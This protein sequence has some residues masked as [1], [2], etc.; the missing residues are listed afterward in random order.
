MPQISG[1][2]LIQMIREKDHNYII[3]I[4]LISATIKDT[5]ITNYSDKL[6]DLKIDKFLEKP[7]SLNKLK[8][9]IKMLIE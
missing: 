8:D 6:S 4:I 5:F 3:K 7:L 1:L 2:D 9:E